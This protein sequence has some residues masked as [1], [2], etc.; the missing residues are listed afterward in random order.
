MSTYKN[1]KSLVARLRDDLDN[2][3]RPASLGNVQNQLRHIGD[4][5]EIV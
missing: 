2:P 4:L 3:T 1:L 5:G